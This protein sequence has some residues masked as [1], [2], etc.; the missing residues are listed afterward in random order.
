[1]AVKLLN[2]EVEY[3]DVTTHGIHKICT[4]NTYGGKK[5]TIIFAPPLPFTVTCSKADG[6]EVYV[7]ISSDFFAHLMKDII[8]FF[9]CGEVSFDVKET[10]EVMKIRDS[11][12]F[13]A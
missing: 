6:K 8:R 9:E 2:D 12:L 4:L 7:K 3:T 13:K 10:L 5:A 1:M 11:L